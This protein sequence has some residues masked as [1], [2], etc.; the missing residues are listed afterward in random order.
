MLTA[1]EVFKILYEILHSFSEN[2]EDDHL[3]SF[4]IDGNPYM[5]D[6]ESSVDPVLFE[7]FK[8]NFK[9]YNKDDFYYDYVFEF[10]KKSTYYKN[11]YKYIEKMG[12]EKYIEK[13]KKYLK[14]N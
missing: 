12:K 6:T 9:N 7:E 3:I 11:V 10:L 5:K 8:E 2:T 13:F 1:F 4:L 14:A